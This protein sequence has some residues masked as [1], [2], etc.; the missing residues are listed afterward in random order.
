MPQF[1]Q[2]TFLNQTFWFFIGFFCFYFITV[3]FFLPFL[4][5]NLKYRKKK[6]ENNFTSLNQINFENFTQYSHINNVFSIKGGVLNSSINEIT[7]NCIN[8]INPLKFGICTLFL[9]KT[10][11]TSYLMYLVNFT[12]VSK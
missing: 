12:G 7:F 6:L 1:D 5:E 4:C 8:S 3:Y 10:V 2:V 9:F 11:L